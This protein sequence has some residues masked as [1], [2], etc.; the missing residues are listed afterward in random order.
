MLAYFT[1]L[2]SLKN[3]LK[4]IRYSVD[5]ETLSNRVH[6]TPS[7]HPGDTEISEDDEIMV[8]IPPTAGYVCVKLIFI[9]GTEW[10]PE[11]FNRVL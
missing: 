10:P 1:H 3:A 6:F 8:E 5:N 4:E 2:I 11:R 7:R 9:D